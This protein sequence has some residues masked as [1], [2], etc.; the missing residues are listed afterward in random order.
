MCQQC[1]TLY[2]TYTECVSASGTNDLQNLSDWSGH[3]RC[4]IL[5][6]S[7]VPEGSLS[8]QTLVQV[9]ELPQEAVV[10]SDLSF[11]PHHG[12]SAVDVHVVPKHQVGDDHSRRAAVAF[13]A[14]D[15]YLTCRGKNL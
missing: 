15:V 2:F 3:C 5:F 13:P 1:V 14:V 7:F 12:Q 9:A 4:N 8:C 11:P 10:G 6:C